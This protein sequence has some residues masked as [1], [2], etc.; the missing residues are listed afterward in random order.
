MLGLTWIFPEK[1][2]N[3]DARKRIN[4]VTIWHSL[5]H[6][7][8]IAPQECWCKTLSLESWGQHNLKIPIFPFC[9]PFCAYFTISYLKNVNRICILCVSGACPEA[10]NTRRQSLIPPNL[11]FTKV[12]FFQKPK[13]MEG[14]VL[15]TRRKERERGQV[16]VVLSSFKLFCFLWSCL[17]WTGLSWYW[18]EAGGFPVP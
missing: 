18:G 6:E 7:S 13:F 10:E 8:H 11:A 17:I 12:F 4:Q 1:L 3:W 16:W 5:H 15:D 14:H 9:Y 2:D